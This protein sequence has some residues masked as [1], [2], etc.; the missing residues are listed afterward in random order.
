[1][2]PTQEHAKGLH[3]RG[4]ASADCMLCARFGW[5]DEGFDDTA[6]VDPAIKAEVHRRQARAKLCRLCMGELLSDGTHLHQEDWKLHY[7]IENHQAHAKR[8]AWVP[9]YCTFCAELLVNAHNNHYEHA[10]GVGQRHS[11]IECINAY[12]RYAQKMSES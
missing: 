5:L 12:S 10:G 1:M 6:L 4:L 7:E 3:E 11:D 9:G 2:T 8:K